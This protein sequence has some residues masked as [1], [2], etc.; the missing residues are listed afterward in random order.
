MLKVVWEFITTN[1]WAS[2]CSYEFLK[3]IVVQIYSYFKYKDF[4]GEW[5]LSIYGDNKNT[6]SIVCLKQHIGGFISVVD[7]KHRHI[8]EE[9][10]LNNVLLNL[11]QS[12]VKKNHMCLTITIDTGIGNSGIVS[13]TMR[14]ELG[15]NGNKLWRG[16]YYN[17]QIENGMGVGKN[18]ITLTKIGKDEDVCKLIRNSNIRK[19]TER[20]SLKPEIEISIILTVYNDCENVGR[21]IDSIFECGYQKEKIQIIV[22]DDGSIDYT[23]R[24]VQQHPEK[25]N[26]L[27][28]KTL[29]RGK[30]FARNIGMSYAC[31]KYIMFLEGNNILYENFLTHAEDMITKYTEIDIFLGGREEIRDGLGNRS[32]C[33]KA[34]DARE[35]TIKEF[36]LSRGKL[37]DLHLGSATGKL[38]S[39]HL[40]RRKELRFE[41]GIY[42]DTFFNLELLKCAE[43]VYADSKMWFYLDKKNAEQYENTIMISDFLAGQMGVYLRYLDILDHFS[44]ITLKEKSK[45]QNSYW[46][47]MRKR[48]DRKTREMKRTLV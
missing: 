28:V 37:T 44:A 32:C 23:E 21:C 3:G 40:I 7:I 30:N 24:A 13:L 46:M 47:E 15:L 1:F 38:Y 45:C 42:G 19:L 35:Y 43:N 25:D 48:I 5:V 36:L 12:K 8:A 34:K 39:N 27:Y 17:S 20:I 29:H 41:E 22:V 4:N 26:I 31:G 10:I 18:R 9:D 6:F 11:S 2:I 33:I 16:E 14:P